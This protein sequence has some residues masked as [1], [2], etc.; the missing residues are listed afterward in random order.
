MEAIIIYIIIPIIAILF[1]AIC[2]I[3]TK[4]KTIEELLKGTVAKNP[5]NFF[6]TPELTTM[7][8]QIKA[9]SKCNVN[10]Q[11]TVD[12]LVDK[13]KLLSAKV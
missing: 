12:N 4:V 3:F 5:I 1:G 8:E 6:R 9:I 10:L 2:I 11:S 13:V 7:T